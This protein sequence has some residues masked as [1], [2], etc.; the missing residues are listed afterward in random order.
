VVVE[1]RDARTGAPL[2]ERAVGVV[3]D[4]AFVDSLRPYESTGLGPASLYSRRAAD[5][6]RGTYAVEVRAPGYT[7]WTHA[8]V[9]V[10][11]DQCHVRTQRVHAALTSAG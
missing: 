1:I 10:G 9:R 2:A 8:G 4:G 11:R 7:T 5:E 3:R 6:R